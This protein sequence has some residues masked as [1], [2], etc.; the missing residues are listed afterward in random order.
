MKEIGV[1]SPRAAACR[2]SQSDRVSVVAFEADAIQ[3]HP[4]IDEAIA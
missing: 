4:V 2:V 1:F 3:F